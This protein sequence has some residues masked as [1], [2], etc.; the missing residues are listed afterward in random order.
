MLIVLGLLGTI[1]RGR[2]KVFSRVAGINL[3]RSQTGESGAEL[4]RGG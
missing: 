4:L 2:I 3:H 1:V